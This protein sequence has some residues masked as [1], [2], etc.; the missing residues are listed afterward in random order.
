MSNLH[1]SLLSGVVWAFWWQT[2]T[3]AVL[4]FELYSW[5]LSTSCQWISTMAT[6]WKHFPPN[7]PFVRGIHRSLDSPNKCRW[8][9][10]LN[11]FLI[12]AWTSGWANNRDAGDLRR[13]RAHFNVTVMAMMLIQH[14]TKICPLLWLLHSSADEVINPDYKDVFPAILNPHG[15]IIW[16]QSGSFAR[17]VFVY[18]ELVLYLLMVG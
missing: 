17:Y 13:H 3:W 8:F 7:W 1:R 2:I 11:F 12:C 9:G 5:N 15:Y 16:Q 18:S 6:K 10:A 4:A 14:I